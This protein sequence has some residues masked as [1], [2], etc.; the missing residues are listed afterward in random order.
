MS[1][2]TFKIVAFA[3]LTCAAYG[4]CLGQCKQI[5][6][7]EDRESMTQLSTDPLV[8]A[9]RN[10]NTLSCVGAVVVGATALGFVFKPK[11]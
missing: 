2:R 1:R 3:V 6:R 10:A 8:V 7:A 4:F 11:S 5:A 9:G